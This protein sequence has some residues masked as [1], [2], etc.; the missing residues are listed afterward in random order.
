MDTEF[1][2]HTAALSA[3]LLLFTRHKADLV[4]LSGARVLRRILCGTET[5][6]LPNYEVTSR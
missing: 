1:M 6:I 5:T 4:F 2:P 3:P